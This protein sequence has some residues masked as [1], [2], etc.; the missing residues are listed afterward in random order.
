MTSSIP[1]VLLSQLQ[2]DKLIK[3]PHSPIKLSI[4]SCTNDVPGGALLVEGAVVSYSHPDTME[5]LETMADEKK[6]YA[7]WL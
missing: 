4:S 6:C 2:M 7:M 5:I 3:P 1:I